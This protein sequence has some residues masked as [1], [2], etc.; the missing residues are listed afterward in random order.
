MV[1]DITAKTN[2]LPF[3]KLHFIQKISSKWDGNL[4]WELIFY[5]LNILMPIGFA[6]ETLAFDEGELL[7]FCTKVCS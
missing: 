2:S 6:D 3:N 7:S 5:L 1:Y 4:D